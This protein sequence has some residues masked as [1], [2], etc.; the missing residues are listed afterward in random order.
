MVL[1]ADEPARAERFVAHS[2]LADEPL[3]RAG[4]DRVDQAEPVDRA[5]APVDERRP[6]ELESGAHREHHRALLGRVV[7]CAR[8]TQRV[9]RGELGCVLAATEQVDVGGTGDRVG[10]AD[11]NDA[12]GDTAVR[13][14]PGEHE[15][16]PAVAVGPEELGVHQRDLDRR[17]SQC[18]RAPAR[19]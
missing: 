17:V 13:E 14:P 1:E 11:L 8:R 16:V 15:R 3:R 2:H 9:E 4:R 7:Q 5:I 18:G 10:D 19:R 12:R 6:D